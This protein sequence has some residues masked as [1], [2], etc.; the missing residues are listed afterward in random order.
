MSYNQKG[1]RRG[2]RPPRTGCPHR[3]TWWHPKVDHTPSARPGA[4][5][6]RTRA[7]SKVLP[8]QDFARGECRG[9]R[10]RRQVRVDRA[11]SRAHP[12]PLWADTIW[13]ARMKLANKVALIT[14]GAQ[15]WARRSRSPCR[16][17]APISSSATL[18]RRHCRMPRLRSFHPAYCATKGAVLAFTC[19]VAGEVAGANILVNAIAVGGILTPPM[20]AHLAG[21]PEEAR[22]SL[23]QLIPLGRLS[24]PENYVSLVIYLASNEHYLVGQTISPNG[25]MIL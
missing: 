12:A 25:G 18:I 8:S 5:R 1:L 7:C 21:A 17:R 23:H 11:S 9:L 16:K 10:V 22:N 14:G 2:A 3:A 13:E 24:R 20:E 6:L 15:V 19:S 4:F